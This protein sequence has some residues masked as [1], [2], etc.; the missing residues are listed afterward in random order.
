MNM[1]WSFLMRMMTQSQPN[2]SGVI[3]NYKIKAGGGGG[4]LVLH[5]DLWLYSYIN[6]ITCFTNKEDLTS[7]GLP[8]GSVVKNPS[9]NVGDEG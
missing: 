6:I 8:G 9:T 3:L 5:K 1:V 4:V 7:L 2:H